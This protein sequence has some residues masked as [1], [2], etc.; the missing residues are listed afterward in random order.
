M[1]LTN[2]C[3]TEAS[4]P[5]DP[6]GS[7]RSEALP[8]AL[9]A[10]WV[11]IALILAAGPGCRERPA[12]E[13]PVT[14]VK[15]QP[16]ELEA[17]RGSLR[18]SADVRPYQQLDLAFR[19]GGYV[20]SLHSV[21]GGP[22][23]TSRSV[24]EGDRVPAGTVLV[25]LRVKEYEE[26]V[27]QSQAQVEQA[28]AGFEQARL[29][30][31]RATNLAAQK[32]LTRAELDGSQ[33]RLDAAK[34]RLDLAHS[35]EAEARLALEDCALRAPSDTLVLRRRIEVGAF[36]APG[37]P[38]FGLAD[39]SRMKVVFGVADSLVEKLALGQELEVSLEALKGSR[40]RGKVSRI[41]PW[42]EPRTRVFEVELTVPNPGEQ[43]R[44]GMIA[45]I[46]VPDAPLDPPRP[47]VPLSSIVRPAGDPAG[48]GV[49][50]IEPR[51][52]G[53]FARARTVKLGDVLG[54][55]V[56]VEAGLAP[57]E[58]II[59]TGATLVRDGERVGVV[60]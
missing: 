3:K 16:V 47:A 13:K 37:V 49:F 9:V 44:V 23:G 27:K 2:D 4:Q 19:V 34:G 29:D 59:V 24:Q 36:V 22:D 46:L 20:E 48:Y 53:S 15:V 26:K 25:R 17:R 10:T 35:V 21:T 28:R 8:G 45:T 5:P 7:K 50:V 30:H 38:V 1:I 11:A 14:P 33:A 51:Q 54:N 39:T 12:Y 60:P 32:S 42:A 40:Y 18:Y 43:L 52:E 41:S 58:Q 55:R 31:E 56:V 6:P 57:G